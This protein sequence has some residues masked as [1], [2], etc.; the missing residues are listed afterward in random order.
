MLDTLRHL[1]PDSTAWRLVVERTLKKYLRGVATVGSDTVAFV[2]DVY[3]DLWPDLTRELTEWLKQFGIDYWAWSNDDDMRDYL[4]FRWGEDRG[5]S[6]KH[7]QD[8]LRA[9][10]FTG[11]YVYDSFDM[12]AVELTTDT[13][14]ES[15]ALAEIAAPKGFD[16][17]LGGRRL[18]VVDDISD[19]IE[20]Y[21]LS[22][23]YDLSSIVSDSKYFQVT[24][25]A[26]PTDVRVTPDGTK[27][28]VI[29]GA[30]D[31][32][33]EFDLG[34]PFDV[35]SAVYSQTGLD[36]STY[37]DSPRGFHWSG[38][39]TKVF[40]VGTTGTDVDCYTLSTAW[41]V[42]SMSYTNSYDHGVSSALSVTFTSDGTVMLVSEGTGVVTQ[43]NLAT[44]WDLTTAAA[45]SK[46]TDV[47]PPVSTGIESVRLFGNKMVALSSATTP[48]LHRFRYGAWR[49]PLDYADQPQVGNTQCGETGASALQAIPQC[50]EEPIG[51]QTSLDSATCNRLLAN[52]VWY[53]VNQKLTGE[54]PPSI[55][56]DNS[57]WG[58]FWYV[59]GSP[60]GTELEVDEYDR[61]RF[62][63]I[64]LKQGPAEDYIVT[65]IDI[66]STALIGEWKFQTAGGDPATGAFRAGATH[67][68]VADADNDGTDQSAA[69]GAVANGDK[70][71]F[72]RTDD[73]SWA[74]FALTANAVDATTY[75]SLECDPD[76]TPAAESSDWTGW[77]ADQAVVKIYH[78]ESV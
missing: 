69:L 50:G 55:P 48:K 19:Y 77:P 34:T 74:E 72:E 15:P 3:D 59:G 30:V 6:P 21:S 60:I 52:E 12:A 53:L 16:F 35:E 44:A 13:G 10:G 36:F 17:A 39:G 8:K 20:Q 61:T 49:D 42:S 29:N 46:A 66:W 47:V 32:I 58:P 7:L 65:I 11:A 26:N 71:R 40:I 75:W 31:T 4:D 23:G 37:Q 9:A 63:K 76:G 38:D 27:M 43:F 64:C 1:L 70:L 51:G 56:T 25:W 45:A 28:M 78:R 33:V 73:G 67:A 22:S 54:A 68:Y 18:Y 41:D 2:D 24:T 62:E 14:D 5:Q 57:K